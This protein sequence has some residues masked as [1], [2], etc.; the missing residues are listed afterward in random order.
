MAEDG[1]GFLFWETADGKTIAD[2]HAVR[3]ASNA[4]SWPNGSFPAG[5]HYRAFENFGKAQ[6]VIA[7][8]IDT[9]RDAEPVWEDN[10]PPDLTDGFDFLL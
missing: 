2:D 5:D 1:L 10:V 6:E 9:P 4:L 8:N 3:N 7:R